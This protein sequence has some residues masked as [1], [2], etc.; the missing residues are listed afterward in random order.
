MEVPA[1]LRPLDA[2]KQLHRY[3]PGKWSIK[4]VLGHLIDTERVMAYRA[5]RIG[6]GDQTPLPSFEEDDFAAAAEADRADWNGL[7]DEFDAVRRST[8]L[9]L[10]RLPQPAW[11]QMGTASNHPISVR[12]LAYV[13]IGHVAHHLELVRDRYL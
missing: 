12:A 10:R 1:L 2:Q 9:M 11:S 13:M 3:A 7:L 4:D 5:L 8:I 6:R